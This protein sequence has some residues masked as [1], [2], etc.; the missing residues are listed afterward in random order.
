MGSCV[1]RREDLSAVLQASRFSIYLPLYSGWTL[2]LNIAAAFQVKIRRIAEI[3]L[4]FW[5]EG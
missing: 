4:V 1:Y 5:S 3:P 2:L